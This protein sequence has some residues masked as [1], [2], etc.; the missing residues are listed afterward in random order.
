MP[1]K[2]DKDGGRGEVE[3]IAHMMMIPHKPFGII[4]Q[5]VDPVPSWTYDQEQEVLEVEGQC[6]D[7]LQLQHLARAQPHYAARKLSATLRCHNHLLTLSWV[8]SYIKLRLT[9]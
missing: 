4:V 3:N 2:R 9:N 5:D 1:T 6:G 8:G 7:A